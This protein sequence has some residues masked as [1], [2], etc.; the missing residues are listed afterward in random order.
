MKKSV[1]GLSKYV[2]LSEKHVEFLKKNF[3]INLAFLLLLNLLVKPFWI[4]GIE[5]SVQNI[6]GAGEYGFYFTLFNFSLILQ[7]LLDMGTT[8][9]NNR[10]IAQHGHMLSKYFSNIVS[11][12]FMLAILY[13]VVSIGIALA[14][15]YDLR[16]MSV[17]AVLILNQFLSSMVLYL[18]SNISGLQLFKTDSALSVL[19]RFIMIVVCSLL[20][21]GNVTSTPMRIEWFV[22]A[23]TASYLITALVAFVLVLRH[24]QYF[25]LSFNFRFYAVFLKQS[26]PYA[27]LILLMA[28]YNRVDSIMIERLLPDGQAQAGIYAQ[29]FR[30][31]DAFSMIAFLFSALLMPLFARMLGKKE[32]V[33]EIVKISSLLLI[34]PAILLAAVCIIYNQE[35]MN[36]M[37]VAHTRES[38]NILGFLMTGFVG[39]CGTYIFGSLLTANG[40]LKQLNIMAAS[41]MAF[42]IAVNFMMIPRFGIE[43]A[44]IT[45]MVTQLFTMAAQA[46]IAVKI[47]QLRINYLLVIRILL[48]F[49][50]ALGIA[51]LS[52]SLIQNWLVASTVTLCIA[53]ILAFVIRI[54]SFSKLGEL[55]R[56]VNEEN[57][58]TEADNNEK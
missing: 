56:P 52:K 57:S 39:I 43:G 18:R 5:R 50:A 22:Y 38:A 29:A 45:S 33:D 15:G 35:L 46:F 13:A 23:Q 25:R 6:V 8:N 28:F 16:Q 36:L 20:I 11:L 3:V 48:F 4:F 58:H 27:L 7:I 55:L 32:P 44:A 42:N 51:W 40:S 2:Y 21:W 12:K 34:V 19:D 37:Y 24:T 31:L 26:W 54:F 49:P 53:L 10:N 1:S 47:L 41:G 14:I 17:L 9:F 30:L